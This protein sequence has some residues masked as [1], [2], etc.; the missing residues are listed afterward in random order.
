MNLKDLSFLGKELVRPECILVTAAGHC[1]VS[2]FRGGVTQIHKNGSQQFFG[3]T[4]VPEFGLLKP[5][6]FAML[7]NGSFLVAHLGDTR[8]G[9]FKIER[10]KNI[11]NKITPFLIEI[12]GQPLPPSNFVFLDHQERLWITVSTRLTPRA[13]AYRSDVSDGFIILV[14]KLGARIVADNIGYTNEVYVTPDGKTLY[15][16]ATFARELLRYDIGENNSLLNKKV[17]TRFGAGIYPDGLTM[18]TQGYLWVTS[19][20]SNSV[21]RINPLS[22]EY[23]L[24]LQDCDPR[25]LEWV[26]QA[27]Q[28]HTMGRPHLD[29]VKSQTLR[30]ISSLA[31]GGENQSTIYLGCL[32]GDAI[33]YGE[34]TYQGLKP[35]HWYFDD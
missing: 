6:G 25:H 8:G 23:T 22:G 7:K 19:I 2:D 32:L 10:D 34:S 14:D 17:V 24:E 11:T 1:Y 5:N 13:A 30:N 28:Q 29:Q 18:D 16:N 21:L 3:G 4:E 27:Y 12:E 33:V 35:A 31:F 26:E 20:V 9:I 15:A